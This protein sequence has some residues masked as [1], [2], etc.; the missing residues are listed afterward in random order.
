MR[1]MLAQQLRFGRGERERE[2]RS[3][4]RRPATRSFD[5]FADEARFRHGPDVLAVGMEEV[6]FFFPR[7]AS[8]RN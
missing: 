2:A 8:T 1:L 3:A 4:R 7:A 6:F 5:A